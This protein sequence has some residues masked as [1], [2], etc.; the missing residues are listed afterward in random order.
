[1]SD[2]PAT[3]QSTRPRKLSILSV[4]NLLPGRAS[5]TVA[6]ST[7]DWMKAILQKDDPSFIKLLDSLRLKLTKL[8]QRRPPRICHLQDIQLASRSI[9]VDHCFEFRSVVGV[10]YT[11]ETR[12]EVS[13]VTLQNSVFS[14]EHAG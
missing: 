6:V 9:Q 11:T 8:A 12:R 3:K 7:S 4:M 10:K 14:E 13:G 2:S 5:N 1:M